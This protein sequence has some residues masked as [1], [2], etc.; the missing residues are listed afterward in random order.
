MNRPKPL[1]PKRWRHSLSVAKLAYA[2]A[3]QWGYPPFRAYTAG[4]LHDIARELPEETLLAIAEAHCLPVGEEE[5]TYPILL[6]C[7]VGACLAKE[8]YGVRNE[9]ILAAI[10]KH[11]VGDKEMSLLDKI[12][13]IADKCEPLRMHEEAAVMRKLA[14]QDLDGCLEMA[15]NGELAYL[16]SRGLAP[17]R[18]M[19]ALQKTINERKINH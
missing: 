14:F 3:G 9:E 10:A 7:A 2:L 6:H 19:I 8:I 15:V 11:T 12:I 5:R 18:R 13:F 1:S 4:L 17:H 16:E